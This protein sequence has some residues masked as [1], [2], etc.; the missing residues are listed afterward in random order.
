[1]SVRY[2][3]A[4]LVGLVAEGLQ[5]PGLVRGNGHLECGWIGNGLTCA[6]EVATEMFT[7]LLC[8][9]LGV[10]RVGLEFRC[11]GVVN[12]LAVQTN[13]HRLRPVMPTICGMRNDGIVEMAA[14][15]SW[16]GCRVGPGATGSSS[17]AGR[18]DVV[19]PLLGAQEAPLVGGPVLVSEHLLE[20]APCIKGEAELGLGRGR[21][22]CHGRIAH[23]GHIFR[24]EAG[25]V[26]AEGAQFDVPRPRLRTFDDLI[27]QGFG[28]HALL[29]PMGS[30]RRRSRQVSRGGLLSAPY[31][32]V[33]V[34]DLDLRRRFS[35]L[36][37]AVHRWRGRRRSLGCPRE[38]LALGL[39]VVL[40]HVGVQGFRGELLGQRHQRVQAGGADELEPSLPEGPGMEGPEP[41]ATHA[42]DLRHVQ[43]FLRCG[44]A[45]AEE[46]LHLGLVL[47]LAPFA[48][49]VCCNHGLQEPAQL[50]H[51]RRAARV[52][53]PRRGRSG[54]LRKT[55]ATHAELGV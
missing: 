37:L 13:V 42:D 21:A 22:S 35:R 4:V 28:V 5:V 16:C 10:L 49:E 41:A 12:M 30:G 44:E 17:A 8:V 52:P 46:V 53:G 3:V 14:G 31:R 29:L 23:G 32:L 36:H 1:M 18:I 27:H 7:A 51:A 33:R 11:P 20:L 9:H 50:P 6:P 43:L 25:L 26:E 55:G 48:S 54:R 47:Q 38:V 45:G 34:P 24:G 40:V 2:V 39:L 19:G 15:A